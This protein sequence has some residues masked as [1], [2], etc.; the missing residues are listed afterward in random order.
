MME[1]R[2]MG[3]ALALLA[4]ASLLAACGGGG[5]GDL[6]VNVGGAPVTPDTGGTP[7]TP[8]PAPEEQPET[9]PAAGGGTGGG[10]TGGPPPSPTKDCNGQRIPI[11]Q[12]CL[13]PTPVN[14]TG[15]TPPGILWDHDGDSD[16]PMIAYVFQTSYDIPREAEDMDDPETTDVD[17]TVLS[18]LLEKYITD[19]IL[20]DADYAERTALTIPDEVFAI[21]AGIEAGDRDDGDIPLIDFGADRDSGRPHPLVA[22]RGVSGLMTADAMAD[23]RL[24]E[25]ELTRLDRYLARAEAAR[26]ALTDEI[27][28]LTAEAHRLDSTSAPVNSPDGVAQMKEA[29]ALALDRLIATL[30]TEINQLRTDAGS[31]DS[32]VTNFMNDPDPD[33]VGPLEP[34][35]TSEADCRVK[36]AE[37]RLEADEKEMDRDGKA[38][39]AMELRVDA[40][41]AQADA[42]AYLGRIPG[43]EA[44]V[45]TVQTDIDDIN[46][47]KGP[48]V[49]TLE[50]EKVAADASRLAT[51]LRD[52]LTAIAADGNLTRSFV[53]IGAAEVLDAAGDAVFARAEPVGT[54]PVDAL[55]AIARRHG[56]GVQ[57][58]T[59]DA[60]SDD[61]RALQDLDTGLGRHWRMNLDD[62][63]PSE[64]T[65]VTDWT[66]TARGDSTKGTFRGITGTFYCTSA[67]CADPATASTFG[68]GWFFT[69]SVP[70][71][72]GRY[73]PL[74]PDTQPTRFRYQDSDGD[75]V[76][77]PL[78]YADYGM[79]LIWDPTQATDLARIGV[80]SR[81][82]LVG[83]DA[84]SRSGFNLAAPAT[85]QN[86]LSA[87]ATYSGTARGLSART[88][89]EVTESGHFTADVTLNARFGVPIADPGDGPAR[90]GRLG[91]AIGNFRAAPGQGDAH[92]DPAWSLTLE[93]GGLAADGEIRAG[94]VDGV[95]GRWR[96][97]GH[98][99]P[100]E[101]PDGFYGDFAAD[102]GDGAAI[103]VYSAD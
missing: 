23:I 86:G 25:A 39:E 78:W 56:A 21:R 47:H 66:N 76:Y 58:L 46:L 3:T 87:T 43:L 36:A 9:P 40:S 71:A 68:A 54:A 4:T 92:V 59:L 74:V 72:R 5:G 13:P 7:T 65:P 38:A 100:N 51:L 10:P 50:A 60:R 69:P 11:D 6:T 24:I 81:A 82:G 89:N 97:R 42:A 64:A 70:E 29:E 84:V 98:G 80:A 83:P 2:Y 19:K 1:S 22:A 85:S 52:R 55:R 49:T 73:N 14:L 77:E 27:D 37:K 35:C 91:G 31:I 41:E 45:V 8:E 57:E 28:R 34:L 18:E 26:R 95:T 94:T 33:G 48:V 20:L 88:V 62:H 61:P 67:T 90:E 53:E 93:E 96:A 101:R 16:T 102:F 103:G 44:H 75:G 79:W 17:E 63:A 15:P 12:T 30:E 32:E 99:A